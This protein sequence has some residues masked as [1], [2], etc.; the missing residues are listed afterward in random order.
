M[1]VDGFEIIMFFQDAF[2][3]WYKNMYISS[4]DLA[5]WC[6]IRCRANPAK[7]GVCGGG[8]GAEGEPFNH[9]AT[10]MPIQPG[11]WVRVG[12]GAG[13]FPQFFN[14]LEK[15]HISSQTMTNFLVGCFCV[16]CL[17]APP[18]N[19][20]DF[21]SFS[22]QGL[23]PRPPALFWKLSGIFFPKNTPKILCR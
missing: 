10:T 3:L 18:T 22:K 4:H 11:L 7:S 23:T 9:T 20:D 19:S 17:L 6:Q 21:F 5:S 13:I 8:F 16:C 2:D 14:A 1:D 15:C 12:K